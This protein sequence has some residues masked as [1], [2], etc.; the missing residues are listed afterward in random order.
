L[1]IVS[2]PSIFEI[3]ELCMSGQLFKIFLRS[4]FA[5]IMNAFM[6]LLMCVALSLSLLGCLKKSG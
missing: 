6:G 5:Q 3:L 4:S 1:Y 2:L